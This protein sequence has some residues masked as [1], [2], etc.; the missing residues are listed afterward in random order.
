[1]VFNFLIKDMNSSIFFKVYDIPIQDRAYVNYL[2][3]KGKLL[4]ELLF[5]D[6][7]Y[8]NKYLPKR[9]I[10]KL[11]KYNQIMIFKQQFM[12]SQFFSLE[13]EIFRF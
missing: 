11:T 10:D 1:M 7:I 4:K 5:K 13:E 6:V 9:I 8:L 2:L 12:S 3:E